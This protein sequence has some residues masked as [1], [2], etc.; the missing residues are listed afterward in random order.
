[1]RAPSNNVRP[2]VRPRSPRGVAATASRHGFTLVEMVVVVAIVLIIL[3]VALPAASALWN[4]RKVAAAEGVIQGLLMTTRAR[5]MQADGAET[6]FLAFVDSAGVQRLVSIAHT[7]PIA[8]M[9]PAQLATLDPAEIS[10]LRLAY[11]NVFEI[12]TNPDQVLPVPMRVVPRY[13]VDDPAAGASP[14]I[15][16]DDAELANNNFEVL[17][18][19]GDQAQRHRNFF[20]MIFSSEGQLVV[21]R[22]VLIQDADLIERARGGPGR[23]DR[24]GLLVGP[25]PPDAP[26]TNEYYDAKTNIPLPILPTAPADG[27]VPFLVRDDPG[28]DVAI[29]F[30]AVDGLLVYDDS[31]FNGL[32]TPAQKREY[33]RRTARPLYVS[34][35]TGAVIRGPLG[36][37]ITP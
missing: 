16:F 12:T 3:G 25:G 34:R 15:F 17:P 35:W 29:N 23:G 10:A 26:T 8:R 13:V 32:S 22:D 36:E 30:P 9:N 31:L 27:E 19:G 37:N 20:T 28:S 21:R 6:G 7:D 2:T 18:G 1:M 24:T 4:D 33:L 5:A 11:Q 14:T